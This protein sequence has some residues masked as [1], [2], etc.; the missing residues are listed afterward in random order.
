[1]PLIGEKEEHYRDHVIRYGYSESKEMYVARAE[2][3]NEASRLEH[4]EFTSDVQDRAV[5]KAR[6]LIDASI[7]LA[8]RQ[9]TLAE[10][11]M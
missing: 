11:P 10:P 3:T 5:I 8:E 2:L 4:F 9:R 1:M 6:N 7:T